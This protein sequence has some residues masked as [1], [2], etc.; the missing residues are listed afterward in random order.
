MNTKNSKSYTCCFTGHRPDKLMRSE[1]DICGDL[2]KEIRR[3]I[4]DGFT[5]FISGMSRGVDIYSAEIVLRL[6]DDYPAL[7]LICA[8]PFPGFEFR[9]S[10]EWRERYN[11]VLRTAD[12]VEYIMPHYSR[13]C[14][15]IRNKWMVDRS[16]R[17]IAVYN[18]MRG[19]TRN[20]IEY[21]ERRGISIV[22]IDG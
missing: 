4:A 5:V 6:R 13:G 20:T 16:S 1:S 21:A 9:W 7:K 11:K 2:E 19:G 22:M 14:F 10:L 8:V 15:Q 3:A 17:L 18:G 12:I